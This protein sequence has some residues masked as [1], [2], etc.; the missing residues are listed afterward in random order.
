MQIETEGLE[1]GDKVRDTVTG[2]VGI[3]TGVH[4]YITGCARASVQP[5]AQPDGKVPDA[6]GID[7]LTLELVEA[8]PRHERQ[9]EPTRNGG[10]RHDP[11][12][13]V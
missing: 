3:I 13:R 7:V 12:S 1:L 5:P 9:P 11:H 8:G 6:Y 10:P 2:L 4:Q